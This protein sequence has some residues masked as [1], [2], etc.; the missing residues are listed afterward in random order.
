MTTNREYLKALRNDLFDAI[1]MGLMGI[2][3][4][5][6]QEQALTDWLDSPVDSR[7]FEDD[8]CS[9]LN[10]RYNTH[11]LYEG[12]KNVCELGDRTQQTNS[13]GV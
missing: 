3:L 9:E 6:K 7:F 13:E 2:P 8:K 1:L 12:L 4:D 5:S 10:I 11:A